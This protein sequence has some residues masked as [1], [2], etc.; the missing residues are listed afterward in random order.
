MSA[1]KDEAEDGP[2]VLNNKDN[3]IGAKRSQ[4]DENEQTQEEE[5][6]TPK[7]SR[8]NGFEEEDDSLASNNEVESEN[9]G[10]LQTS[11]PV[12]ERPSSADESLSIPDDTPSL[13][14]RIVRVL[15]RLYSDCPRVL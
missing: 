3:R 11:S 7:L 6:L 4:D 10:P 9:F 15:G 14:V 2:L 13:Q 5:L 12:P 1:A 8:P